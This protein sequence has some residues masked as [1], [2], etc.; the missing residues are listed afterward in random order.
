MFRR[1]L[2]MVGDNDMEGEEIPRIWA[3]QIDNLRGLLEIKGMDKVPNARV[4]ELSGVRKE[5]D[6]R[7]DEGFSGGLSM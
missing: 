5:V 2:C 4:R 3:L 6:E 7:I 1:I